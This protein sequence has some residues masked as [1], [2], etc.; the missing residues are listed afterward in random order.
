VPDKT[1]ILIIG[2]GEKGAALIKLLCS[3]EN[4]VIKG[5]V[6]PD[7]SAPGIKLAKENGIPVFTDYTGL[8]EDETINKVINASE[9]D[10]VRKDIANIKRTNIEILG[11]HS[12]NLMMGL[13]NERI[14]A[15]QELE[16][17][18]KELELQSWGMKKTNEGI[19][20]L[21]R[22]LEGKTEE[23][24]RLDQLKSDFISTVSHELRTPLTIIREA[25]A[26]VLD[27]ILGDTT[28][29]QRE[30]LSVGL[31]DI[32]RLA[33]II[34]DLLDISKIERGKLEIKR[35]RTNIAELIKT[36]HTSFLPKARNRGIEIGIICS[37]KDIVVYAEKDQLIQVFNNLIGNALKFTDKGSITIS[38]V[39][40][41]DV[42]ECSVADTG[43]GLK[44]EDASKLFSKFQQFGRGAG[45]GEKGTGLGLA[46]SKGI[47]ELY[48]GKIHAESQL[49]KGTKFI[50]TIPKFTPLE[51][52]NEELDRGITEFKE[53][54]MPF[55]TAVLEIE[56]VDKVEQKIGKEVVSEILDTFESLGMNT[57]SYMRS[58]VIRDGNVMRIVLPS[59]G[60]DSLAQIIEHLQKAHCDFLEEKGKREDIKLLFTTATYPEDREQIEDFLGK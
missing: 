53:Q 29:E 14:K 32:D 21:Y 4:I 37:S 59:T 26:Q 39:D 31:E 1:N 41:G 20:T 38:A 19:K 33:R 60:K 6:D 16:I 2:G 56:N 46:I 51:L 35:E 43:R 25:V 49:G 47:V 18:K 40:K 27:G 52:V 8:L 45:P 55:S 24:K 57:L 9:S 36:L 22:E 3:N 42:V 50:F 34:N 13:A 7:A 15:E 44:E 54:E 12:I 28:N 30:V 58:F 17:A 48:K 10:Q 5:V 23:L 11:K